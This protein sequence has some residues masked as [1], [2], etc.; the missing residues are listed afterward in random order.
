MAGLKA[1]TL[2]YLNEL[3]ETPAFIAAMQDI[4]QSDLFSFRREA[5]WTPKEPISNEERIYADGCRQGKIDVL[6]FFKG[7]LN[8]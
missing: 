4:E 3:A 1:Q 2:Q 7:N 6:L 5:R 8:E